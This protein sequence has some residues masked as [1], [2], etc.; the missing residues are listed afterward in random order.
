[1]YLTS[2][3]I[4]CHHKRFNQKYA[5]GSGTGCVGCAGS[6]LEYSDASDVSPNVDDGFHAS[7]AGSAGVGFSGGGVDGRSSRR[8]CM[9]LRGI[10]L[11][12]K[13]GKVVLHEEKL[14]VN[15]NY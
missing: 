1:M 13:S 15:S 10:H 7:S 6:Q 11:A 12:C 9:A 14:A 2:L 3:F 8:G 4:A 5:P